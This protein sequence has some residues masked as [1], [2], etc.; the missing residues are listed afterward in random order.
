M[1]VRRPRTVCCAVYCTYS[2]VQ[3]IHR[4]GGTERGRGSRGAAAAGGGGSSDGGGIG[5]RGGRGYGRETAAGSGQSGAREGRAPVASAGGCGPDCLVRLEARTSLATITEQPQG[6][7]AKTLDALDKLC[8][9]HP[10]DRIR[11][12]STGENV[13]KQHPGGS[14]DGGAPSPP[15]CTIAGA[16][17]RV[18]LLPAPPVL[19]PPHKRWPLPCSLTNNAGD[20]VE[21]ASTAHVG[22][23]AT[24]CTIRRGSRSPEL[25]TV[26]RDVMAVACVVAPELLS[27]MA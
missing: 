19:L 6:G 20:A 7:V 27:Q 26:P 9:S 11:S 1:G 3:Y 25:P 4:S 15:R 24:P 17:R 23:V 13:R 12:P 5:A 16:P 21:T 2:A 8:I 14:R 10:S 22:S 18:L